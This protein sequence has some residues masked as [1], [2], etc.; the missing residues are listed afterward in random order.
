MTSWQTHRERVETERIKTECFLL[1]VYNACQMG[2]T[3]KS[4]WELFTCANRYIGRTK[5]VWRKSRGKR[6]HYPFSI[7]VSRKGYGILRLVRDPRVCCNSNGTCDERNI[8]RLLI[9][10][11]IENKITVIR[12]NKNQL[13]EQFSSSYYAGHL[14][15]W[16]I[17]MNCGEGNELMN[18]R[19]SVVTT[20]RRST[21]SICLPFTPWLQH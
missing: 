16:I 14:E 19:R 5:D 18:R 1:V 8:V 2:P 11:S 9:L 12:K 21:L 10:H 20:E 3:I 17:C 7:G 6:S 15:S 13:T 4:V